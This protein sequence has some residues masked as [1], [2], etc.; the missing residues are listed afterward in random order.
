MEGVCWANM[1]LFFFLARTQLYVHTFMHIFPLLGAS[2]ELTLPG[3]MQL[4]QIGRLF[5][6][7]GFGYLEK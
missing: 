5:K 1:L 2:H 3:T 7:K 4:Q 6:Q